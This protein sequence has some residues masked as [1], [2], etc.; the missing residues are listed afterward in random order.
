MS[1][2]LEFALHYFQLG[3]SIIP[4]MPGAKK[5]LV[6]WKAYQGAVQEL[7]PRVLFWCIKRPTRR[8]GRAHGCGRG[9]GVWVCVL[10]GW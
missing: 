8:E 10:P 4:Q 6:K 9:S 1:Q 7:F 2:M 5:P 3:W